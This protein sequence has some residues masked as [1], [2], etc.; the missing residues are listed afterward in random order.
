MYYNG[1]MRRILFFT[2]YILFFAVISSLLFTILYMQF[3]EQPM[4]ALNK[5]IKYGTILLCGIF[6]VPVLKY[7]NIYNRQ[8]LGFSEPKIF[9]VLNI[10]KGFF[11]S[12]LLLIPLIIFYDYLGIRNINDIDLSILNKTFL[13]IIIYTLFI[14]F[15][16]S[17]IE[18]SYFRGIMIQKKIN[19]IPIISIII[20]SSLIYSLFHFIKIPLI[21]DENI[22]WNTGLIELSNVFINFF[23]VISYDAAVTLFVFG[24]LLALIRLRYQTISYCI[25]FHAGFIFMI[26]LFKQNSSVNYETSYSFYLS[27]YD[28]FT[29]TIATIWIML[30]L[31]IYLI[32]IYKVRQ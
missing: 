30:I 3:D 28:Q 24:T 16:I 20:F 2:I 5:A 18:E 19:L 11:L 12:I 22:D 31:I 14:S 13:Y 32:Y 27:S 10:I 1:N 9:F 21:I 26:K 29:G 4:L 8:V 15:I 23:K 7:L 25:G 6:I 17:I